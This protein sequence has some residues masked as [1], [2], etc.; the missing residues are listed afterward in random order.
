[1]EDSRVRKQKSIEQIRAQAARLAQ[2]MLRRSGRFVSTT[3]AVNRIS[4]IGSIAD[5]YTRNIAQ[6]KR[7]SNDYQRSGV[8]NARKRT[9]SQNT[10][11][12][13]NAG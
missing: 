12:G 8:E 5:K 1:M 10:Y 13:V 2:E 4:R 11:M 3:Q 6:S 7:F 9:Y